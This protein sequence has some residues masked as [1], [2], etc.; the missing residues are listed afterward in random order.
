MSNG[1]YGI[2]NTYHERPYSEGSIKTT[3]F[4]PV[5][6]ILTKDKRYRSIYTSVIFELC[7]QKALKFSFLV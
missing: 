6:N 7:V 2:F 1:K 3:F 5:T 4:I